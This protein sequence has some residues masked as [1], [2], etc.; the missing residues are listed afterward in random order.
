MGEPKGK[1]GAVEGSQ[2]E[3]APEEQFSSPRVQKPL[4]SSPEQLQLQNI[5]FTKPNEQGSQRMVLKKR[6]WLHT[7][8]PI[9]HLRP[10][11]L[12]ALHHCLCS[13]LSKSNS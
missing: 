8:V 4:G 6:V 10:L 12:L 3:K 7:A 2:K 13:L 5:P 11:L 9:D 1:E